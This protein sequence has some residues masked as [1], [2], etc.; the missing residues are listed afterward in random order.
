ML[1]I[2][3]SIASLSPSCTLNCGFLYLYLIQQE[4]ATCFINQLSD[5]YAEYIDVIQPVQ[6]AVYEMKFGLSMV[7]SSAF[8]KEFL[9]KVGRDSIDS[10]LVVYIYT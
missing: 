3:S 4:T 9:N 1:N 10:I 2:L 6:V 7:Q 8:Q 5:E